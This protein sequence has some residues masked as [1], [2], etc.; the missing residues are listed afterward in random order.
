[1]SNDW[2]PTQYARFA[3]ERSQPFF[4]LAALIER[5]AGP[6]LVDLGCG[7]GELTAWLVDSLQVSD[8]VGIDN[9]PAM[10]D[11]SA[12]HAGPA[13]RFAEADISAW[14][15]AGDI[16][17]VFANAS[18]Q[19]VPDHIGLLGRWAAALAPGG[20]LAVQVPANADH[21]AHLI[22]D[23]M[24]HEAPYESYV[25]PPDPV[26]DNVL[27]PEEY[28]GL[29][30][31]LGFARQHVRLQVYGYLMADA[32]AVVEWVKGTTLTRVR[33]ALP[34]HE[35]ERFLVDYTARLADALDHRAPYFYPFK[36]ILFWGRRH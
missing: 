1:M 15:S 29:L 19:W 34:A 16:D 31:S 8:A 27:P 25:I 13:L 10:L 28:A 11:V 20:Q 12:P 36:R 26:A 33:R 35:Y 17:V 9:S 30:H 2:D 14:T 3:N 21:P 7:S 32:A 24:R 6:R 23:A 18:L 22:I 5:P 4:D